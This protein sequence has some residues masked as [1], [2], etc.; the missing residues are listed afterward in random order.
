M[1]RKE[2][3]DYILTLMSDFDKF[4]GNNVKRYT[5][6]FSKLDN[7][8]F[9]DFMHYISE[10]KSQLN[11]MIPNAKS[12][13]NVQ[14]LIELAKQRDVNLFSKVIFHDPA[15][16]RKY[17][18]AYKMMIIKSPIRRLSQYLFHKISLPESD[19]HTNP[20]TG[21][22][23]PPDKGAAFSA[24]ETQVL[25]SKGLSTSIIEMIKMRSGDMSAYHSM[26]YQ[27]EENGEVS[28]KDVPMG[29]QPRSA[30]TLA[31]YFHGM[32]IDASI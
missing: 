24:I 9:D 17:K 30:I 31:N 6:L 10:G 2:A 5:D 19:T 28:I 8:Q 13:L 15:T 1:N 16:N 20:L 26:K 12:T 25:A 29:N 27:I 18:T 23:I 14:E 7:K 22:V 32:M 4:G 11:V 3:E 21:Q